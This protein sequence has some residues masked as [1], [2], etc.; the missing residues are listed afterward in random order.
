[1]GD[2]YYYGLGVE[3]S[4]VDAASWYEKALNEGVWDACENLAFMYIKGIGVSKDEMKGYQ[5][6]KKAADMGRVYGYQGLGF[7]YENGYGVQRNLSSAIEY[8]KKVNNSDDGYSSYRLYQIYRADVNGKPKD[9]AEALRCL[10]MAVDNGYTPAIYSLGYEFLV[11]EIAMQ[12]NKSAL[13]YITKAAEQGYVFAMAGLG[14]SYYR[15]TVL[16][17]K[18]Y[19]KAFYYLSQVAAEDDVSSI[20]DDMLAEVYR[21]LGACYRFGRGTEKDQS[22]ASYYTEMAAEFGDKSSLD[23][24]KMM[25]R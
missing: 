24:V 23:A 2:V 10:K 15:G 21:D 4:N 7:C 9:G 19:S 1:M 17:E 18:D 8:Y 20:G 3:K 16:V 14:I 25:K 12:N 6:F 11:G 13:E 5:L 22:L